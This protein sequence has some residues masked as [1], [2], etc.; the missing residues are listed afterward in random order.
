M[1]DD[2][3]TPF[4]AQIP[5][6]HAAL[7]VA[8]VYCIGRNYAEHA[9][10]LGN[11]TPSEPV[12]FLKSTA[13]LRPLGAAGAT[14]FTNEGLHHEAE[15]VV[16]VGRWLP[17]G[18]AGG[19]QHVRALALGLDLTRR[20]VQDALKAK[21]LPWTSSKSFAGSAVVTEFVPRRAFPDLEDIAFTFDV[22]GQRRQTGRSK[23]MVFS[24]PTILTHLATLAPL[25]PGDIIFTGTPKGVGALPEGCAL[26]LS[27]PDL[28]AT[29]E[30]RL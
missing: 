7:P 21:G 16:L 4:L 6:E 5:A 12:V 10:E 17:H 3:P 23:D 1:N 18:A 28:D 13:A 25:M 29:F 26:R 2:E 19:W 30:G 14:A 22:N 15:L 20:S 24:V 9:K 11:E 8:N 27:F